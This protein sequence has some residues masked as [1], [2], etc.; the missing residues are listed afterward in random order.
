MSDDHPPLGLPACSALIAQHPD[1]TWEQD[2][3]DDFRFRMHDSTIIGLTSRHKFVWFEEQEQR[4]YHLLVGGNLVAFG[5]PEPMPP[6]GGYVEIHPSRWALL[7]IPD[8]MESTATGG[9]ATYHLCLFYRR[10]DVERWRQGATAGIDLTARIMAELSDRGWQLPE[11][12]KAEFDR[13]CA[14][15]FCSDAGTV[16]R[17]RRRLGK[18]HN[19]GGQ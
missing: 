11:G 12:S 13:D 18:E 19:G 1:T 3:C 4:L 6:S 2:A 9:G 16:G 17:I 10:E 8:W 7:R 14:K 15:K 5:I